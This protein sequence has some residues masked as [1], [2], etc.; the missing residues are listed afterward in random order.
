LANGTATAVPQGGVPGY[1]Y[2]WIPG[3]L[4]SQTASGLAA[5]TYTVNVSDANGCLA[6]ST[7]TIGSTG[8]APATPGPINGPI[9]VCRNQSGVVFSITPVSGATSYT[10]TLPLGVSGSSSSNAITLAFSSTYNTGTISVKANNSCGSSAAVSRVATKLTAAPT[11]PGII[12]G[13]KNICSSTLTDFS[14]ASVAN[15]SSYIWTVSGT[16]I[17]LVNGQGTTAVKVL[18]TAGFVG[19]TITVV[20]SNCYGNSGSRT[21]KIYAPI[22]TAPVFAVNSGSDNP[23]NG[24]CGGGS[25]DFEIVENDAALSY[26][27][28]APSGCIISDRMGHTGNPLTVVGRDPFGEYEVVVTFPSGF[29]SGA[30]TVFANNTCST[31]PVASLTVRSKPLAPGPISG[32]TANLCG[33]TGLV[34]SIAPVSGATSYTWTV[35]SGVSIVSNSGTSIK[36]NFGSSFTTSGTLKVAAKNSCG[37]SVTSNLLLYSAPE[38]PGAISGASTVC[39]SS[40][41]V[42]YTIAAVNGAISYYWTASNGATIVGSNT[43]TSVKVK[44]TGTTASSVVLKVKSKNACGNSLNSEK[45]IAVNAACRTTEIEEEETTVSEGLM[46]IS[47]YPN[48]ASEKLMINFESIGNNLY[49]VKLIDLLGKQLYASSNTSQEGMNQLSIDV[50]SYPKGYL[51]LI[52]RGKNNRSSANCC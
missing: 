44:F 40:T 5:G 43:G 9:G 26:T 30:V 27:W 28:S 10:W 47:T 17:S 36:V 32:P 22:T 4:T 8:S 48:P 37:S 50:S 51:F 42:I 45:L 16:G 25:Y 29:L 19:G 39:K 35:P 1:T 3:L 52:Y 24:V 49:S 2:S 31:S 13:T 11:K 14:I 7:T 34:Y 15:A 20:A 6:S 46:N 23:T 33:K 41:S 18:T 12:V 38:I 21:M